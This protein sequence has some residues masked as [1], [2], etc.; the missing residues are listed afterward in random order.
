MDITDKTCLHCGYFFETGMPKTTSCDTCNAI[1]CS[2]ACKINANSEYHSILC[3]H[4]YEETNGIQYNAP[5]GHYGCALKIISRII[6][7][8]IATSKLKVVQSATKE[9]IEFSMSNIVGTFYRPPF[10]RAIHSFRG[11]KDLPD[12]MFE[13]MFQSSYFDSYLRKY[14]NEPFLSSIMFF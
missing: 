9:E 12:S 1:Y 6:I 13:S 11:G 2:D 10:T 3:N 5:I 8:I 4:S 14:Y 7:D